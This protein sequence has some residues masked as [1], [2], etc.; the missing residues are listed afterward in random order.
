L[1]ALNFTLHDPK[2]LANLVEIW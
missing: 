1:G 2:R